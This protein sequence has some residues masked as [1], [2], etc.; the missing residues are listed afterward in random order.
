MV[1]SAGFANLRS[2]VLLDGGS[3]YYPPT[4][5]ELAALAALSGSN[6]RPVLQ[7]ASPAGIRPTDVTDA[8]IASRP[9]QFVGVELKNGNHLDAAGYSNLLANLLVGWP[10][11]ENV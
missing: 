9:G 7:I 1:G 6:W 8:L 10:R 2:V 5:H 3:G 11:P 4:P